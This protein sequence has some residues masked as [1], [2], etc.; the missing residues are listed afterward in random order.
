MIDMLSFRLERLGYGE[1]LNWEGIHH[2]K[3]E[4]GDNKYDAYRVIHDTSLGP[5]KGGIRFHENVNEEELKMLSLLMTLKNSLMELPYGGA[6][7]GV[8]VN[9]KS[10]SKDELRELSKK[11]A[12]AFRDIIGTWKDIPAPDVNTNSQIIAWMLDAYQNSVGTR[13]MAMFTSKPVELGGIHFREI[14]T[15]FGGFV[16]VEYIAKNIERKNITVAIQGSGNVGGNLAKMLYESG[17][18]VVAIS[19]SKS[20]IFNRD[21]LN[22]SEALKHKEINGS[23]EGYR[24]EQIDNKQLLELD[25]DVLIPAA[26]ELQ[27]DEKN[28]RYIRAKWIVEMANNPIDWRVDGMLGSYVVPDILAN[29]GGVIGSYMEWIYNLTGNYLDENTMKERT[30]D[31]ILS[32]FIK[33][34]QKNRENMREEAIRE[35]CERVLR[36][37]RLRN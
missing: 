16:I 21:G 6:K 15:S 11:Y 31:K 5:S 9:P 27:I 30:K 28:Y 18:R 10:L 37:K 33:I 7:G 1:L 2:A 13:D 36:A 12:V 3:I 8:R 26:L 14:S 25:V 23:F 19:D 29:S 35:A 17:Y 32:K 4:I 34:L 24:A 20:G 22:I